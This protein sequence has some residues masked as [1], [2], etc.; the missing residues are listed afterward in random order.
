MIGNLST[1]SVL[2]RG[3]IITLSFLDWDWKKG[4]GLVNQRR[5]FNVAITRA[6]ELLVVVGNPIVLQVLHAN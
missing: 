1:K 3:R 4:S 5:R 6:K 2:E